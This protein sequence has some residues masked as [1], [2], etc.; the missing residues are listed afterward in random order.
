MLPDLPLR[1]SRRSFA[2]NDFVAWIS[3][4]SA[5]SHRTTRGILDGMRH[6]VHQDCQRLLPIKSRQSFDLRDVF[7][8][9]G[10]LG[11]LALPRG[12]EPLFQP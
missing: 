10:L 6:R 5:A 7:D 12:I 11:P 4:A 1:K 2:P 3:A 8:L 9:S